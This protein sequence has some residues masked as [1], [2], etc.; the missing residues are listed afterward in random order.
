VAFFSS[1]QPQDIFLRGHFRG[2]VLLAPGAHF[3]VAVHKVYGVEVLNSV[4]H[5]QQQL[6]AVSQPHADGAPGQLLV[7]QA[8]LDGGA[9]RA[10]VAELQQGRAGVGVCLRDRDW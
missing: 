2:K 3:D 10:A 5:I 6:Q 9:Q 1:G 7:Q 8:A 4:S